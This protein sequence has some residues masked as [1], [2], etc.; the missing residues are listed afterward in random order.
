MAITDMEK[1][2][3]KRKIIRSIHYINVIEQ[4]T[5]KLIGHTGDIHYSGML[6][7]STLEIPLLVDIPVWLEIPGDEGFEN[8]VPLVI[9]GIWNQ[10]NISPVFYNT[11]CWIINPSHKVISAIEKLIK[12]L[13]S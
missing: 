11:G 1:L 6:L 4:T 8:R 9:S 13:S 2:K 12:E 5:G 3:E 10:M 7:V